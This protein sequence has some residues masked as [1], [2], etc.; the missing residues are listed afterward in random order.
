LVEADPP[1][2]DAMDIRDMFASRTAQE[3]TSQTSI[4]LRF[5]LFGLANQGVGEPDSAH[6]DFLAALSG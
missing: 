2:L 3:V 1:L 4:L 6:A 5:R